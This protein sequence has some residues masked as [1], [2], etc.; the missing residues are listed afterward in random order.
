MLVLQSGELVS[1]ESG[2]EH[3]VRPATV[4]ICFV[5]D[6]TGSMSDKIDGLVRCMVEFVQEL[7]RLSLDWR[8]TT[9]PFGDLTVPGDRV[10]SDQPFVAN[11]ETA[12]KQLRTM[13]R[14]SG[15]GNLGESSIEAMRAA[16]TKPFR[17]GAVKVL[18]LLTDEPALTSPNAQPSEIGDSLAKAEA[19][20][21][22]ASPDL[23][24]FRSWASKNAGS[25]FPIAPTMDTSAI[26][27]LLRSLVRQVASVARDVHQIGG[28]SVRRY[29]ELT[30]RPSSSNVDRGR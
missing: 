10:E 30:A 3:D 5:F 29:L 1:L 14:F 19:I 18:V 20:C 24:Y 17:A 2:V 4:D 16:L 15:G 9:V 21:F 8:I 27:K 12:E 28:G 6:T 22:V 25:W 23:P 26:L 13:P 7:S 11:R